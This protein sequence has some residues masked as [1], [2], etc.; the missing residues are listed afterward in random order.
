MG[1]GKELEK[2]VTNKSNGDGTSKDK[3]GDVWNELQKT[4][5]NE[6]N[7]EG[8]LQQEAKNKTGTVGKKFDKLLRIKV[9]KL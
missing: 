9:K 4:V 2:I 8:S 6:I 1:V 3:S 5:T 7:C